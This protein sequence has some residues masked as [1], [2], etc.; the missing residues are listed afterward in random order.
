MRTDQTD[1]KA[2]A[3]GIAR[4]VATFLHKRGAKRVI[5]FG[6]LVTDDYHGE[7]SDIDIYFEGVPYDKECAIAGDAMTVFR[8]IQLDVIPGGNCRPSFKR[9]VRLVRKEGPTL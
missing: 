6:S 1:A 4:K 2:K 7:S 9:L 5:L 3:I 8:Q